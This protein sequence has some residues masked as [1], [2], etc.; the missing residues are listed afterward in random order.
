MSPD[1]FIGI[2][3][4]RRTVH[5]YRTGAAHVFEGSAVLTRSA[6]EERGELSIGETKLQVA[7]IYKLDIGEDRVSILFP[8]GADFIALGQDTSQKVQHTCGRDSYV[9]RFFFR[10]SNEWAE[11]WRVHGPRKRYSSLTRYS[12]H[13]LSGSLVLQR[14]VCA[15]E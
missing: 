9:G 4:V 5:D 1:V 7:R 14:K 10:S 13:T 8:D 15:L 3:N 11:A 2:W 12:R 6:F